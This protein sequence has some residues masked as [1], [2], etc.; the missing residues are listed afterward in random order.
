VKIRRD[1]V[2]LAVVLFGAAAV[3]ADQPALQPF[4]VDW[5][6]NADSPASMA[7]LLSA[8]AGK[9][10]YIRVAKGH[11]VQ[12]NGQRFRIW[13]V[14]ITGRATVPPREAAPQLAAHLAR[15]G[16]NCVRLHFLD[17]V[18]PNGL[19]A[20][21]RDTTQTLDPAQ[22]D[23]LDFFV[24]QCRQ[25]GIYIDLNL[26]VG[27][28][29][30]AGDGVPDAELLGFA[31]AITYFNPR[32][33][34]LQQQ[35]ARQLLTHRNPYT[36]HEYRHE[37]AVALVELVNENSLVE[38]WFSGRLLGKQ[39]RKH[40]GTWADIPARYERELTTQ[41]NRWLRARLPAGELAA[42][43]KEA[44][45]PDGT[46][47]PRLNPA[48]FKRASERRFRTEATFYVE[49]ER[50]YFDGM[51][52]YL[53]NELDVKTPLLGTSDHN[54]YRSG[55]PLLSSTSRLDVVDGHVYWQHPEYVVD[56]QTG[57]HLGFK[58]SNT[59]MVNDPLNSTVVQLSRSAV[60]GKPYT[61]SEVNH[62]FPH[63]YACEGVPILAAYAA[64]HDWD[65]VF[66]YTLAHHWLAG[67]PARPIGHFDLG[68][69]S[70]KMTQ[71]AAGA[72]TFLRSDAGAARQTIAR[73]YSANQ[74]L[75]SL[76]LPGSERPY[77]TP[78]FARVAAL[79]HATRIASFDGARTTKFEAAVGETIVSDTGELRW[80][81]FDA[82]RGRFLC[83]TPRT[84]AIVGYTADAE[85]TRHLALRVKN[86]FCAVTLSALDAK[87][88][89]AADRL[90]LAATA[91]VANSDMRWNAKRTTLEQWGRVPP[92]IEPVVG[93]IE[94]R[95]MSS[96]AVVMVQ[97]LDGV[98]RP[99]GSSRQAV[100][101][102]S[103]WTFPVGDPVTTW[104]LIRVVR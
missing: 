34:E 35:Y 5:T 29:Y 65:G 80:A 27:H 55:Y 99:L 54:H 23:R 7:F 47:L 44:G 86:A 101:T 103:A 60:A 76:R 22:L 57:R 1:S 62:P 59:P 33:I 17:S 85:P 28:I 96:A 18:A 64:L 102:G 24:D 70:V 90:V 14:N 69:D 37:P 11:L 21:G 52:R 73:S 51:T 31:K 66:W 8:P 83:D 89:A 19:V 4:A 82:H 77:F 16:V 95:G 79:I 3:R 39:T 15:C 98:G 75:E 71:V 46:P 100:E 38:S 32:L 74:V 40:P 61:V 94:L 20:A 72:L 56:P 91:R 25:R 49:V 36:G 43:R 84:Q 93:T 63:E 13:G 67:E 12:P 78:G 6:A 50:G 53:R 10:G 48:E 45:L 26:N 104:Y 92:C 2:L 41:Y 88:I 81:G 58:I 97:P 30:K 87:P 42:L 68:P 9:D